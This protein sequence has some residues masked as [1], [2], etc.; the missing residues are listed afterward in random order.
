MEQG[1]VEFYLA[2]I[3]YDFVESL[4]MNQRSWSI[5]SS[6]QTS[7]RLDKLIPQN[8][9]NN[10]LNSNLDSIE[11]VQLNCKPCVFLSKTSNQL[12]D[13]GHLNCLIR[14]LTNFKNDE[15]VSKLQIQ[16]IVFISSNES[17][18]RCLD[19]MEDV[20]MEEDVVK[21]SQ[22]VSS[23]PLKLDLEKQEIVSKKNI[24]LHLT[25]GTE[26]FVDWVSTKLMYGICY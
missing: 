19:D 24:C 12:N 11:T 8:L 16:S 10:P 13:A 17:S 4:T 3:E 7:A 18:S 23:T 20:Q 25:D 14:N 15:E 2:A 1:L 5:L 22:T 21:L 9:L 6:N 26:K